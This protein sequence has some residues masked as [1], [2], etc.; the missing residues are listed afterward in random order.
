[1]RRGVSPTSFRLSSTPAFSSHR[2][3]YFPSHFFKVAQTKIFLSAVR[4]FQRRNHGNAI[5]LQQGLD[6]ITR[7][8]YAIGKLSPRR[9]HQAQTQATEALPEPGSTWLLD[10]WRPADAWQR[11]SREHP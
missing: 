3:I 2:R 1:M 7:S 6:L 11:L 10:Y 8:K 9:H 5:T 4:S